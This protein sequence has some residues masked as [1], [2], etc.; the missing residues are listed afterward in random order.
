M[1]TINLL[2]PDISNI[3]KKELWRAIKN[4]YISTYG[5]ISKEAKN[6]II[7][8]TNCK[9]VELSNSGSAALLLAI[10]S[11]NLKKE[12]LIITSNYTFIATINS[13]IHSGHKPWIFDVEDKY[14]S[15]N[16]E[17]LENTLKKETYLRSDGIYHKK[18][19]KRVSSIVIV[20]FAG[21]IPDLK[22]I[23]KI[24]KKF[25]LK[26]IVDCAGSFFSLI[27]DKQLI[28]SVDMII[29]SFNGNKSLTAGA[30]GA[31]LSNKAKFAKIFKH[32]IDN[33][34]TN[35]PYYHLDFGFNYKISNLHSSILLGQLKR[36]KEIKNKK[37]KIKT[38]YN[39][40]LKSNKF[41]LIKSDN[42]IWQ[43]FIV[44]DNKVNKSN[45]IKNAIKKKI[46]LKDF[47]VPMRDQKLLKKEM[48]F[49]KKLK[50]NS[51]LK[52]ILPIPSSSFLTKKDL[53]R[54]VNF[55]NFY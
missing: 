33:S 31:I 29:T 48:I 6:K 16:L 41:K 17:N 35:K 40:E 44:L 15:I 11:L 13:I 45:L 37:N 5:N 52:R 2:E 50:S 55:L 51:F 14:L 30:G 10:K 26:I 46:M 49:S 8:L 34:K 39:R 22:K 4:N 9:H 7:K 42:T 38:F 54:V 3:E 53:K 21:I 32:L 12:E 27:E 24:A 23:R 25:K 19:N 43:N 36:Y 20:F 1:K 18:L 47:W 28:K